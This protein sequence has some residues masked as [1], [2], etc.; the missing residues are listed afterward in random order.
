MNTRIN[1]SSGLNL[2]RA[3]IQAR[4]KVYKRKFFDS[5][6]YFGHWSLTQEISLWA[7]RDM[8]VQFI[9][10]IALNLETTLC[11]SK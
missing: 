4:P 7:E 8:I 11:P 3:F 10:K 1:A 6:Y 2:S 9:G 5:C